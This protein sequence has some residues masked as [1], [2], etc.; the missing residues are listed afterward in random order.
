MIKLEMKNCNRVILEKQEK[1]QHY[2]VEIL[3]KMNI[4]QVNKYVVLT[5]FTDS[6]LEKAL[7]KLIKI[8][9]Y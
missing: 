6:P 8:F 7:E 9:E 5:K 4:L 2:H 1:Y 3:I